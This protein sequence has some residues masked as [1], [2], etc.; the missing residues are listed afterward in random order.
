MADARDGDIWTQH[1]A[2]QAVVRAYEPAE[3]WWS[4]IHA[5]PWQDALDFGCGSGLW[6]AYF[7]PGRYVGVDQNEAMIREA[8]R[9]WSGDDAT[10]V[11]CPGVA[12]GVPLPFPSGAF[13]LVW[14]CTVL[15]H[16]TDHDKRPILRELRRVLRVGG[17]L[18]MVENTSPRDDIYC[19]SPEGWRQLVEP[20]GFVRT[21]YGADGVPIDRVSST[22]PLHQLHVFRAV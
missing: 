1:A 21:W 8:Q 18:V 6:R 7:R 2:E 20:A 15:Q 16:N 11:C 5:E 9:R 13:D 17:R 3:P 19:H 14:T 10:F 12:D 4:V 22:D